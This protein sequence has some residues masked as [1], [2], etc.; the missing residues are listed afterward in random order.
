MRELR[1][2]TGGPGWRAPIRLFEA[3]SPPTPRTPHS[4]GARWTIN[5][6]PATLLIWTEEQFAA[7]ADRPIDAQRHPNGVWCALRLD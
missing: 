6:F 1:R 4:A 7:L 2:L 3:P 5:G